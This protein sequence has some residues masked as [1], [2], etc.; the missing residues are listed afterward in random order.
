MVWFGSCRGWG[1][2]GGRPCRVSI[3]PFPFREAKGLDGKAHLGVSASFLVGKMPPTMA[4]VFNLWFVD[5]QG[6]ADY[7]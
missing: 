2:S 6:P 1:S 4:V 7:V 3:V 5:L